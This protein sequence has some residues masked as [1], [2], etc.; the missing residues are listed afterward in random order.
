M[1]GCLVLVA[2]FLAG[3]VLERRWALSSGLPFADVVAGVLA[4]GVTMTLGSLQGVAQA[5][6]QRT[7]PLEAPATWTDGALVRA[8]GTLWPVGPAVVA[9]VSQTPAVYVDC[10]AVAPLL[11]E[12]GS[13]RVRPHWRGLVS[14]PCVIDI[15]GERIGLRGMPRTREW[16]QQ[17]YRGEPGV[18][19]VARHLTSTTWSTAIEVL[20]VDL[21]AAA[22]L[23]E[24]ADGGTRGF[25]LHVMNRQAAEALG[26]AAP[27]DLGG[28]G[29]TAAVVAQRIAARPW[30]FSER[31]VEPGARVTV[32]GTFH[33]ATRSLDIA[34][35]PARAGQ[36][37][38]PGG[39]AAGAARHWRT[40]LAFAA[41]IALVTGALHVLVHADGGAAL[42]A[43]ASLSAG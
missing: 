23:F 18:G 8:E 33:A 38:Q 24:G 20:T 4:L 31:L 43:L 28:P 9:P 1:R 15:G 32:V 30:L 34:L 29:L 37:L 35:S 14:A 19:R 39:A 2:V 11:G 40:T 13:T 6:R 41:G 17:Q 36:S 16:P 42:K 3:F 22:A 25:A 10:E 26:V 12:T 27:A 7:L 5:W 21:P